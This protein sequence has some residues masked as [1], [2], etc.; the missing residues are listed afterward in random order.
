MK[1]SEIQQLKVGTLLYNGRTEGVVKMDGNE[2]V[3]EILIPVSSMCNGSS[4]YDERPEYWEVLD[5]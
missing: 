4:N 2:K 1:R 5:D 3:I